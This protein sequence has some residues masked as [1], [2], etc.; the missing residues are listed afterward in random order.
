MILLAILQIIRKHINNFIT[1]LCTKILRGT[2]YT[3]CTN[4]SFSI[5]YQNLNNLPIP[6]FTNYICRFLLF[7][8]PICAK[9]VPPPKLR[10]DIFSS[11]F[12]PFALHPHNS[13]WKAL[14]PH[15]SF[16]SLRTKTMVQDHE[17]IAL[18]MIL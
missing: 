13:F 11:T 10:P 17:I 18:F 3:E 12:L 2:F 6:N 1:F 14:H 15:S 8:V 5:Q 9:S 4:Y 16:H 7:W